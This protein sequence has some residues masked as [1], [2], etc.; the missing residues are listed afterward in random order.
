MQKYD[1]I[2]PHLQD[3]GW[4]PVKDYLRYRDLLIMFKCRNGM[5]PGYLCHKFCTRFSIH[6][7]ETRN[8]NES[9][10]PICKQNLGKG[11]LN[12]E[13]QIKLSNDI[14]DKIKDIRDFKTFRK[15]LKQ[16]MLLKH[17]FED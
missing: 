7:R 17:F 5:A 12:F 8:M 1:H 16:N 14:D 10:I 9:D 13:E 15:Q 4:L 6:D 3:L 2:I 11:F